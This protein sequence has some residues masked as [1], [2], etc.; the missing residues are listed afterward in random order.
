MRT[1][2]T[3]F[4]RKLI[5]DT[6][7]RNSDFYA[8]FDV[9]CSSCFAARRWWTWTWPSRSPSNVFHILL[10][11]WYLKLIIKSNFF[12]TVIVRWRGLRY[13]FIKIFY[14]LKNLN[15]ERWRGECESQSRFSS[16]P[17]RD[18]VCFTPRNRDAPL[19]FHNQNCIKILKAATRARWKVFCH[20]VGVGAIWPLP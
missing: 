7:S 6:P 1:E 5:R 16:S 4:V 2:L 13:I 11:H 14:F 15:S 10:I 9:I 8:F 18:W 12:E 19:R 17:S 20:P 3:K